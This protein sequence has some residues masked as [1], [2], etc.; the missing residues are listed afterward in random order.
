MSKS[1]V[2]ILENNTDAIRKAISG[3]ALLRA[4][5]A[6]A[7]ILRGQIRINI[8]EKLNRHP[9]GNLMN[10][11]NIETD[12]VE[13]HSA[14]VNVGTTV[15]YAAIHEFGGIIKAKNGP[16]LHFVVDGQ[17]VMTRSVMI[18]ARPYIRPAVDERK[19]QIFAAI[20]A[21]LKKEIGQAAT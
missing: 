3:P 18:P 12:H 13:A 6:G 4:V 2:K 19:D 1:S 15:I 11:I 17:H 8:R 9:T 7:E 16:F 14:A 20:E 10:S 21:Q 5:T